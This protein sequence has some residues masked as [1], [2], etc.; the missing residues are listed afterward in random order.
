[1][2]YL[3]F[4]VSALV[5]EKFNCLSQ[6]S[7]NSCWSVYLEI[8]IKAWNQFKEDR[9][10]FFSEGQ[11]NKKSHERAGKVVFELNFHIVLLKNFFNLSVGIV[12]TS[13]LTQKLLGFRNNEALKIYFFHF[14]MIPISEAYEWIWQH[15]YLWEAEQ[16]KHIRP[17]VLMSWMNMNLGKEI[18]KMWQN[19]NWVVCWLLKS[20]QGLLMSPALS[21][22]TP[23]DPEE[24][25]HFHAPHITSNKSWGYFKMVNHKTSLNTFPEIS[26][27]TRATKIVFY[28]VIVREKFEEST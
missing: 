16:G 12:L 5:L 8:Y 2:R 4:H 14:P 17:K 23:E 7:G 13:D 15:N 21:Q 27:G 26:L 18:C 20:F 19:G 11:A 9:K 6:F 22:C 3:K 1:M 24:G 10:M 28:E 25:K